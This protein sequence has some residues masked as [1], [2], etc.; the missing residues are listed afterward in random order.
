[1]HKFQTTSCAAENVFA[2]L[3]H[4]LKPLVQMVTSRH[5]TSNFQLLSTRSEPPWSALAVIVHA[6][7]VFRNELRRSK[8]PL[9]CLH[10][11]TILRL[12][13]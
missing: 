6:R 5:A 9:L 4:Y 11:D 12:G 13:A 10:V 7:G 1:M 2:G 8:A 3:L